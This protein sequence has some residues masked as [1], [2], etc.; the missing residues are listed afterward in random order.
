MCAEAPRGRRDRRID[1]ARACDVSKDTIRNIEK[2]A[3]KKMKARLGPAFLR[4]VAE[5]L[6]SETFK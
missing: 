4:Q 6:R 2:G 5:T 1:I 3:I